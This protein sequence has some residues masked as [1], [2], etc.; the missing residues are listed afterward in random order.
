MKQ[1]D[2][3]STVEKKATSRNTVTVLAHNVR[4]LPRHLDDILKSQSTLSRNIEIR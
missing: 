1:N 2:L 4:S 3:F